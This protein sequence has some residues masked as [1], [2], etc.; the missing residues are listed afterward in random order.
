M[1]LLNDLEGR[2]LDFEQV[3][4]FTYILNIPRLV[5]YPSRLMR[6]ASFP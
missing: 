4:F 3:E 5:Q 1:S 2:R 6:S